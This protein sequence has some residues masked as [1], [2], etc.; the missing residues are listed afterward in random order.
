MHNKTKKKSLKLWVRGEVVED[1]G[2][3]E[4]ILKYNIKI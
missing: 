1:R 2:E 3:T 4:T